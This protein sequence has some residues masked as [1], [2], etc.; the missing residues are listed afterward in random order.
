MKQNRNKNQAEMLYERE[1]NERKRKAQP[2]IE[3]IECNVQ[4]SS[5]TVVAS[6]KQAFART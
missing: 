4:F 5:Q 3:R 6:E 2:H 1:K